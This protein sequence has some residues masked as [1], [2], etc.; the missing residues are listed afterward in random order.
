MVHSICKRMAI[1]MGLV[2]AIADRCGAPV[3]A[4]ELSAGT[5]FD[6]RMIGRLVTEKLGIKLTITVSCRP[7]SSTPCEHTPHL[8]SGKKQVQSQRGDKAPEFP[9]KHGVGKSLVRLLPLP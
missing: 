4:K 3:S 6:H 9:G 1:E 5:R 7:P 8:R 2:Q